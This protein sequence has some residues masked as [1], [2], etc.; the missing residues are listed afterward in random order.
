[1]MRDYAITDVQYSIIEAGI[2]NEL[3]MNNHR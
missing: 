2:V 3:E 1:M